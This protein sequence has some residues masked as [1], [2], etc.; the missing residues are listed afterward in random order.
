MNFPRRFTAISCAILFACSP[1]G[2][3]QE[4]K[5]SYSIHDRGQLRQF[6]ISMDEVQSS[7]E[8]VSQKI[9][10]RANVEE[11]RQHARSLSETS[12]KPVELVLYERG[13]PRNQFTR[14]VLTKD[15]LVQLQP[16]TDAVA[17]ART[18]GLQLRNQFSDTLVM[19]EAAETGGALTAAELLRAQ[20]GVLSSEPQL[21]KQMQ[22][23][24]V[25]N[26]TYFSQ[27][28]HL[29]NTG[30]N[31]GTAGTDV[32]ITNVWNNYR[33]AGITIGILDDGIQLTHPDL[34]S[35][36]N[37]NIDWDFNSNDNDPSPNL[38]E[39]FHGTAVA[40]MAAARGNNSAGVAGSAYESTLVGLRLVAG[41]STDLMER[42]AMLHSN[43]VIFV[44]N[45][46]W[47]PTD[48]VGILEAPGPLTQSALQEGATTGRGGKGTIYVWAGGNGGTIDNVNY[49][50]YANSIYTFAIGAVSDRGLR[51]DYSE[52]GACLV[53]SAPSSSSGRQ[54]ITTTDLVGNNGYN[55][56]G[57]SGEIGDVSYT[58]TFGGTSSA[59]P[60]AAGVM[61]V[62]LQ[63]NPNLGYRDLKEILMRSATKNSPATTG[64]TT[65]G[66]G[67]QINHDFGAGLIN[68]G[69]AIELAT[70][71]SNLGTAVLLSQSQ[72]NLALPIPDNDTNGVVRTFVVT[73]ENFR[74]EY[75]T[76]AVTAPHQYY[77][78]LAITITSPKGTSSRLSEKHNS[79]TNYSYNNWKFSTVRNWG[80]NA[81]GTWTVRVADV[82]AVDLGTL[83]DLRLEI[84]GTRPEARLSIA[85]VSANREISLRVAAHGWNYGLQT[86]TNLTN[87]SQIGVFNITNNGFSKIIE[88]NVSAR[89]KFYR[90]LLL[91]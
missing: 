74:V 55:F 33:G 62:I 88:T 34:V 19:L 31:G 2:W 81:Y 70:N 63:A 30:Q 51:T 22:K 38:T 71:W 54:E 56:A 15:I 86:S 41:P 90:A 79:V 53:V 36:L 67:I 75:V 6:E 69:K 42:N 20:P 12:G 17:L 78:D 84:H 47:G 32:N 60:L 4:L 37:T 7:D 59:A 35:N 49:D 83:N 48:A 57:A 13:A 68:A 14:R 27:Q 29:G 64:W 18:L 5:P 80:E 76:L 91:P 26:D 8:G 24:L 11:V 1:D 40:G 77:G 61:A 16:G 46:S 82:A 39:D 65:N 10:P 89:S 85:Q 72:T 58:K 73:N 43:A 50:G 23:R 87:W 21:A 28:W 9:R 44:K 3:A 52:P 25:P 66:S 45:N